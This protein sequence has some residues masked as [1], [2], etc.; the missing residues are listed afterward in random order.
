MYFHSGAY[1]YTSGDFT[2]ME[3]TLQR[4]KELIS[5]GYKDAFIVAFRG[6]DRIANEE[7]KR[8][9]EKKY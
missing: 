8:L 3:A 6:K 2:T 1:K 5:K 9:T 4:R 7:A